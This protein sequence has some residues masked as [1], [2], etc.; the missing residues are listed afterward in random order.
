MNATVLP[1]AT[2]IAQR[3]P[4]LLPAIYRDDPFLARYL[5]AFERVLLDIEQSIAQLPSLFD[6]AE[7]PGEFL[8]WLSSWVAFTLRADFAPAQQR[9]FLARV[10]SLYRRRGTKE[11]LRELL[12]IFT[13][14]AI[15]AIEEDPAQPHFFRV[16]MRLP[17]NSPEAQL[18][19]SAIAHALIDLEKPAHTDYE[20]H[21]LFPTMQIGVTSTIGVDTLLGTDTGAPAAPSN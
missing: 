21:L 11:N 16:T 12:T 14:G 1:P 4:P 13:N 2:P 3:L 18:R 6:P 15:P 7:T 20:L 8:P 5:W 19:Q 10:A 9:K 17:A